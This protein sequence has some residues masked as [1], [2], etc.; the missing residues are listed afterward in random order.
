M[1]GNAWKAAL[2]AIVFCYPVA[3]LIGRLISYVGL[4]TQNDPTPSDQQQMLRL[5]NTFF[6][7]IAVLGW[8]IAFIASMESTR[9]EDQLEKQ[10]GRFSFVVV[11]VA[12]VIY[13][14]AFFL[15]RGVNGIQAV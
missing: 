15:G 4:K 14:I 13:V 7:I 11:L 1:R 3:S 10:L 12:T 9:A 8:L 2:I 5:G 6:M